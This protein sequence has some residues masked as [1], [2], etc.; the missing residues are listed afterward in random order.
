MQLAIVLSGVR[1]T[2]YY[3]YYKLLK[4][5]QLHQVLLTTFS[6]VSLLVAMIILF[7]SFSKCYISVQLLGWL[8]ML[9]IVNI[10]KLVLKGIMNFAISQ[11]S[12][13]KFLY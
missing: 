12:Y 2:G 5:E 1:A 3:M 13:N 7:P 10:Y 11:Y 4:E 8:K 6:K 9:K